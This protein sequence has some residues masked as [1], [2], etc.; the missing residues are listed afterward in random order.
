MTAFFVA[1]GAA[2][3]QGVAAAAEAEGPQQITLWDTLKSAGL[4]GI[5]IVILSVAGG[6]LVITFFIHIRNDELV[7]PD[8]YEHLSELFEN[9][10]YDEALEV[11]ENNPSWL[12][13]VMVA[14]LRRVDEGY[15][16]IEKS[17][18][19]ASDDEASKL[20]QRVGYL[21]L[22]ANIAPMLGLLGTVWG[23]IL[24]F[25]EIA[26][27]KTQPKPNDLAHGISMALVTTFL[28]L[29]VA[30]PVMSFYVYFR[31]KVTN[32][33]AEIG[34]ITEELMDRFRQQ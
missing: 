4:I 19:E 23:M 14:G 13:T 18:R 10:S 27:S 33:D 28:G 32:A 11:C 25:N 5:I 16:E 29:L 26:S 21:N 20:Q 22:I 2:F 34:A 9:E 12:S 6:A 15:D 8:L 1:A 31:N 24:A 3:G 17:M 7:P 30:I